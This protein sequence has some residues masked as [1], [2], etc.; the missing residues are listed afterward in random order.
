M[1]YR[2]YKKFDKGLFKT[3]LKAALSSGCGTYQ[4]FE[5]I[6]LSTLNLHAPFKKKFIRANHAPYMTKS[7]RK[8]IM[9]RSQLL[10]KYRKSKDKSDHARYKKQRNYVSK[11][12]KREK[13]SF[14]KNLDLKNILDNK[15]FW[16]YM[17]PL[18]S[19][20]TECI[21]KISLVDG[22]EIISEDYKL[23]ETFNT[24]FK[25]AVNKLDIQGNIDITDPVDPLH[26]KDPVNI[27]IEKY[28]N[29][30]SILKIKEMVTTGNEFNFSEISLKEVE[31]QMKKTNINKG[32]TF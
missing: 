8:A 31:D 29:H 22:N 19:D 27:A 25:E 3:D 4:E 24:F 20:K 23:A 16:K 30:P 11:M 28:K 5:N 21:S 12:Y 9:R 10:T 14:Y 6:F 1:N 17:K 32:T 15:T 18:F 13:K 2:D 26:F 7:L